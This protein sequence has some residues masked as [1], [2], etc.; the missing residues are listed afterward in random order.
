[1]SIFQSK[2]IIIWMSC[3]PEDIEEESMFFKMK[4]GHV[5][6]DSIVFIHNIVEQKTTD[7][8]ATGW[9]F[10]VDSTMGVYLSELYS[11]YDDAVRARGALVR[12][13]SPRIAP[14]TFP[15]KEN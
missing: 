4:E 11:S 12:I 5:S 7:S 15:K 3:C 1:M 8:K 9:Q 14:R 10:A 6:T 13:N 2:S